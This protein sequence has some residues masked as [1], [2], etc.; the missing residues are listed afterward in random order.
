MYFGQNATL[1]GDN[2]SRRAM[3][4][5]GDPVTILTRGDPVWDRPGMVGPKV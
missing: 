1:H 3:I 4:R 5:V 2:S